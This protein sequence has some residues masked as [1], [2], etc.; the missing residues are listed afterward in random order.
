MSAAADSA[1][2]KSK[3]T[4]EA[5][6]RIERIEAFELSVPTADPFVI[7]TGEVNATRSVLVKALVD[8]VEGLG[9]GSC[10]PPVTKE[11]QPDALGAVRFAAP[12]LGAVTSLTSLREVLDAKLGTFPVARAAVET[13]V[14]DAWAKK[15]KQP[16]WR[17]LGGPAEAEPIETDITIP[18][19]PPA[20]MAELATQWWARGFKKLKVK[21]GKNLDQDLLALEAIVRAV[22]K[23]AF[24]PDANGGLTV[25]GALAWLAGAKKLGA[26]VLCFEQPCATLDELYELSQKTNVPLIADES[27]KTLND[28]RELVL[29]Q[30]AAGVNLKLAK[31]GGLLEAQAIGRLAREKGLLVMV[32]GMVETRL[33]MTAAAHLAA[34]LGG[35]DFADLDTAFLLTADPFVGGY[36]EEGAVLHLDATPGLGIH[37]R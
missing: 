33:G 12:H 16:L 14:L 24:Q 32:G 30:A 26:R 20:R 19:L 6:V 7:A 37:T 5:R 35:A 31:S 15:D 17:A 1:A 22:P 23:A 29:K 4:Y 2:P 25:D 28:C 34:S 9:E 36:R 3:S 11:D 18:I 21:A 10:L 13:A 27:V 8:G